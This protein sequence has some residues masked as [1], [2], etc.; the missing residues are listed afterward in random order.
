MYTHN[1]TADPSGAQSAV[2]MKM[3][4][5]SWSVAFRPLSF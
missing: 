2:R 3:V 1:D 5:G 4:F